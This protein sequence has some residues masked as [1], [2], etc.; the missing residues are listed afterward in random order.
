MNKSLLLNN[1]TTN[2][3]SRYTTHVAVN[4]IFKDID[5]LSEVMQRNAP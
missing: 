1:V 2:H 5:R 3:T 4:T